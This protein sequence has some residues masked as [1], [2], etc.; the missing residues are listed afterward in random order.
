MFIPSISQ[1]S[2]DINLKYG[3]SGV[4]VSELQELLVS[5]NCLSVSPTGY[6]G[7]L[8]LNGVKCF[9]NKHN[10][11]PVSGYFGVLSRGVANNILN[12]AITESNDAEISEVG[13]VQTPCKPGDMFNMNTGQPCSQIAGINSDIKNQIEDL[14]NEVKKLVPSSTGSN[15]TLEPYD[16][17]VTFEYGWLEDGCLYPE[18]HSVEDCDG[19]V[20]RDRGNVYIAIDQPYKNVMVSWY[21]VSNPSNV[22]RTGGL[23]H[24]QKRAVSGGYNSNVK[25]HLTVEATNSKGQTSKE[26]VEF[27]PNY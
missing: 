22:D 25:Y 17:D 26:E 7:L 18:L 12:Q 15:P 5:E 14:K 6:F 20:D 13:S 23:F 9:Q 1:A 16:I 21:P 4:E 27:T 19:E 24:G 11:S 8:T 2:I 10:I 3:M